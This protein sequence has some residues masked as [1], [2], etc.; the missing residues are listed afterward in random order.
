MDNKALIEKLRNEPTIY[1]EDPAWVDLAID[2]LFEEYDA[3]VNK[4][5]DANMAASETARDWESRCH[6]IM[7]ALG[8]DYA[9]TRYDS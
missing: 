1:L 7:N 6:S 4:I 3:L 2:A 5:D 8:E 9:N